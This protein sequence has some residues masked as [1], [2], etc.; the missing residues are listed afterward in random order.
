MGLC[1]G[2]TGGIGC[3]KSRAAE[4]F[5]ELG[6]GVVDTD[7]IAHQ[8]TGPG[9]QAIACIAHAFGPEYVGAD[10]ALDRERMRA[11]VFSDREAKTRLEAVLH[12]LI[13]AESRRRVAATSAPYTILVVP[14][15]L[16]TGSYDDVVQ[17][18]LVVDCDESQQ[19]AR[20]MARSRLS[21]QDVR[22]IMAA[23]LSRAHRLQRADDVISNDGDMAALRAQVEALH[24]R[25]LAAAGVR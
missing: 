7:A 14:L 11:L 2:L 21:E 20:T 17:R 16:E 18:V 8:L 25:Y 1:V 3:G 19:V 24:T 9:G 13:R 12:P 22:R 15:L 4:I 6:A 5:A 23:Q 10:G